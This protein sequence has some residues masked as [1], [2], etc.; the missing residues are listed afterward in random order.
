MG[1]GG[2]SHFDGCTAEISIYFLF[3]PSQGCFSILLLEERDPL[4]A[5]KCCCGRKEPHFCP[6]AVQEER[7]RSRERSE[8]EAESTSSGSEDMPV[9]RILEAELAVE[10]KTEAY[11][12]VNTESSVRGTNTP[13]AW[14]ES[15]RG[16][17]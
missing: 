3:A 16:V 13:A 15:L 6:A 14:A 1:D 8:N 9:E 10:P 11:S 12:D 4:Q 5:G 2:E 17:V 7:Q